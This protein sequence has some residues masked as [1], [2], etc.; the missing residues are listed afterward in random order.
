VK[1]LFSTFASFMYESVHIEAYAHRT[2]NSSARWHHNTWSN[3]TLCFMKMLLRLV[4]ADDIKRN[5]SVC[6]F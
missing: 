2:C 5:A 1:L 3:Y 6:S 4:V